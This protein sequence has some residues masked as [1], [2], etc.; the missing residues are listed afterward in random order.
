MPPAAGIPA[1]VIGD[2]ADFGRIGAFVCSEH[3]RYLTG[4]AIQV[5][6]GSVR[7]A[8]VIRHL[9]LLTFVETATDAQIQAIEDALSELPARLPQLRAYVIGRDLKINDANASFAVAADFDNVDGYVAYRDDPEHKRILAELI[10]ADP[11]GA[12]R[13]AVRGRMTRSAPP[14]VQSGGY[15]EHSVRREGSGESWN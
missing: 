13:G 12:H 1:G 3:A 4:T 10:V 14:R 9:S 2:P 6:G 8:P 7:S 5:D 11:R 15:S